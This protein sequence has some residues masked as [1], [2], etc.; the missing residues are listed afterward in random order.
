MKIINNNSKMAPDNLDSVFKNT[1]S[2]VGDPNPLRY[3]QHR[4]TAKSAVLR[5]NTNMAWRLSN[6]LLLKYSD[7]LMK[8]RLLTKFV[9]LSGI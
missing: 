9:P 6:N 7:R 1:A 4:T 5:I 3:T 2:V 8:S